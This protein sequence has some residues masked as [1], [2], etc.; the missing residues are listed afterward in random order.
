[1]AGGARSAAAAAATP[2]RRIWM[3]LGCMSVIAGAVPAGIE[4]ETSGA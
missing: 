1:M 4:A 3:P 2:V